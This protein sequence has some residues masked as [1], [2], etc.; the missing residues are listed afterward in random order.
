MSERHV[1]KIA[2]VLNLS[3]FKVGPR[4]A[5]TRDAFESNFEKFVNHSS[6]ETTTH[7]KNRSTGATNFNEKVD[8][9][10]AYLD[11]TSGKVGFSYEN[12]LNYLNHY[13]KERYEKWKVKDLQ[14]FIRSRGIRNQGAAQTTSLAE[15]ALIKEKEKEK[16]A[17]PASTKPTRNNKRNNQ[18]KSK[19]TTT[20]PVDEV[21]LENPDSTE[22]PSNADQGAS[23]SSE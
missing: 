13:D 12:C 9:I 5:F 19:T 2:K 10:F 4:R 17:D 22:S 6:L 15:A 1:E 8:A 11:Y 18:D 3:P 21:K 14:S 7:T 16:E 23:S 20:N